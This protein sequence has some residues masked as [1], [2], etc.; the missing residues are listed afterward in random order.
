MLRSCTRFGSATPAIRNRPRVLHVIANVYV[1]GSTQLVVDLHEHLG[2][3][4]EMQV[5]TAALP[6]EGQHRGMVI[7]VLG[8]NGRVE[9]FSSVLDQFKPD[10]VHMHYWGDVDQAWYARSLA[11]AKAA[12]IPVVENVN[13]PV[14]PLQDPDV[15]SYVAVS[16]YVRRTFMADIERVKVIYP[17]INLDLFRMPTLWDSD[18]GDSLGM[19]YRLSTDKLAPDAIKAL[20]MVAQRRPRTRIFVIGDGSLFQSFL[21][22]VKRAGVERSFIFTG[23]VPYQQLPLLLRRFQTFVAPVSQE[24]F[25]QV[26][27][28]AMATGHAVAGYRVGALPEILGSE[29]MLADDAEALADL[30]IALLDNPA[31][32]KDTGEKNQIRAAKFSVES[33]VAAYNE[34]YAQLSGIPADEMPGFPPAQIYGPA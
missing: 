7:H 26:V 12:E 32:T 20:I 4:Y 1:G 25:G 27:P 5:A 11:A 14:T 16:E 17:G 29:D 9:A 6:R 23:Q 34:I 3:R 30:L 15:A 2:H 22:S 31:R 33:M 19:V 21:S 8:P 24:S 13:T 10:V 18:A 28:M